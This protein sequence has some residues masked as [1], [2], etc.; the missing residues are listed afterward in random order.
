MQFVTDFGIEAVE[1][2]SDNYFRW[3]DQVNALATTSKGTSMRV[4][5]AL[6]WDGELTLIRHDP[7]SG[8]SFIIRVDSTRLG[9]SAGGTRA[10]RYASL[11]DALDDAGRL[12]AAMS[13]KMA[14]SNLP[15]GGGK[16]VIALPAPREDI[17]HLTW[18]RILRLHAENIDRLNGVYWTGP[19]VNTNSADMDTLNET[20]EFVF[21]RSVEQRGAGSS[22]LNTALG[23]F[24]AMKSTAYRRGL[25]IL[26]GLTVLVQGLGAVG[27]QLATLAAEAG[28]RVLVSDIDPRRLAWA[29]QFGCAAV[30]AA[31]V[32]TTSCDVFAPCAMGGVIDST[33]AA[34]LPSSAVVGAANNILADGTAG[35]I[36][37]ARGILYAPDF[38][39][40]AGG[41]FHLVGHEVL[42]WNKETVERHTTRIG[43]TLTEVY[44]ISEAEDITTDAAARILAHRRS[45]TAGA[46]LP[47]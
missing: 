36:L 30:D 10:L 35:A 22:A 25:G 4:D 39:A 41:A 18:N 33:V 29:R 45:E 43:E 3:T 32:P 34:Q 15:M 27:G 6:R 44:S 9:R 13:L 11:T 38:V 37:R 12:A 7:E 1:A 24:E 28:A 2:F 16:S 46:G 42:G 47:V 17:D 21:G 20:T 26:D 14:V 5:D 23:V 19:D 40:N 8:A 31:D